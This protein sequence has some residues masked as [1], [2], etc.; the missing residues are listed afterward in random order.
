MRNLNIVN[1]FRQEA[2]KALFT[3][4]QALS[5]TSKLFDLEIEN[6]TTN[7]EIAILTSAKSRINIS[8]FDSNAT[9]TDKILDSADVARLTS[10]DIA[11]AINTMIFEAK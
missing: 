5:V 8:Y 3:K 1:E 6:A 7:D 2:T 11:N 4:A 9:L 10:E